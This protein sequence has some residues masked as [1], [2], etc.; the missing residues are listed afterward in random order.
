M[1]VI[2]LPL[3][4]HI[5]HMHARMHACT[6]AHTQTHEPRTAHSHMFMPYAHILHTHDVK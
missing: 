6:Y 3:P 5:T 2:P 1:S 4:K